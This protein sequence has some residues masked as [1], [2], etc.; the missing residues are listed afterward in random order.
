MTTEHD[1]H[2]CTAERVV[3]LIDAGDV[4]G[5]LELLA[6]HGDEAAR[7]DARAAFA[8]ERREL[9]GGLAA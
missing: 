8:A 5:A 4:T 3:T 6:E 9:I 2:T 1:S 7:A